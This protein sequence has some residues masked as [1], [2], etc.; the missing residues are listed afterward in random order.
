M[1]LRTLAVAVCCC[2][3]SRS[4]LSRRAFSM[5]MTACVA[6]FLTKLD[7]L[8]GERPHL[9]AIDGD[10]ADQLTLLEH[11]H[12]EKRAHRQPVPRRDDGM[13]FD[14]SLLLREIDDMDHLLGPRQRPRPCLG[15]GR[16][17]GSRRPRPMQSARRATQRSGTSPSHSAAGCR[18]GPADAYCIRQHGLKH[19]LQLA[20]RTADH[21][22]HLGGRRLLLQRLGQLARARLHARRTAA[23]SRSR[24]PPG[25]RRS[26][27]ERSASR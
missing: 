25:R 4:S 12:D 3:D 5:A 18:L 22:E 13:P 23:R 2:S 9:V 21:R 1:I 11:R 20:G 14:V 27:P 24:S 19:G 10:R 16:I 7:L 26:R 15:P 17:T 8:L 6:K